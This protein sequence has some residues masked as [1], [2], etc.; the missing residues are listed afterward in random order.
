MNK[1]KEKKSKSKLSKEKNKNGDKGQYRDITEMFKQ[2]KSKSIGEPKK[3]APS[4][5]KEK[6]KKK[7]NETNLTTSKSK[8]EES[9]SE[10][11]NKKKLHKSKEKEEKKKKN[12]IIIDD[13]SSAEYNP[14]I[15]SEKSIKKDKTKKSISK[16]K[17]KSEDEMEIDEESLSIDVTPAKKRP[18]KPEASRRGTTNKKS[19]KKNENEIIGPLSNIT[20]VLTGEFPIS[21]DKFTN[22][23]KGLGARVTGSVSSKT[24]MLIH[25]DKLEDG[26]DFD[27][28]NKYKEA[29]KKKVTI[30][31]LGDFEEYMRKI[32]C[33]ENWSLSTAEIKSGD[34]NETIKIGK[35]DKKET[36]K[37]ENKAINYEGELW[38]VKY[39]PQELNDIIGNTKVISNFIE[40][41]DD[42]EDVVI[43]GNK[44]QTKGSFK[45]GRPHFENVNARACLITGDPGIGKT[46]SVR[47]I[48]KLKG[49]RTFETNASEQRNK[50]SINSKVGFLFDN[51][52]LF[53]GDIQ[54]KNLIIMDEVDGMSG[55]EDRGGIAALID[56]IKKTRVP[57]VCIANDRQNRKLKTLV[58]YCYDL[59]FNKPDKRQISNRLMQI[60]QKENIQC[61]MNAL[62]FLC[63]SVGNDIRQC[64]NFVEMWAKNHNS[65]KFNEIQQK[66]GSFNKDSVCMISNFDAS[67]KLLNSSNSKRMK[68]RELLDLYFIDYDLIPLLIYENYLSCFHYPSKT[69]ELNNLAYSSDLLSTSD[70]LE[71]RIRGRQ[72]W[73]LLPDKGVLGSVSVC[74]F[75][76]GSVGFPKFPE[77]MGKLMTLKKTKREL[78]ELKLCFP[79]CP[80]KGIKNEI[81]PLV[82]S[83]ITNHINEEQ[84]D[85]CLDIMKKHKIT[86]ELFK[87]NILDLSSE[88]NRVAF[89]HLGSTA[90][91]ALTR[92][93]NKNFKTSIIRKKGGKAKVGEEE[94]IAGGKRFDAEGNCIEE[95]GKGSKSKNEEEDDENDEESLDAS[96]VV[97]GKEKKTKA[98]TK[99]KTKGKTKK[100]EK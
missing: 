81:A 5:N 47:L 31:N 13:E 97:N 33:N 100:K 45:G 82:L 19:G 1:S 50:L 59:K 73:S 91:S 36:K 51:T 69:E 75:I 54:T 60:C 43:N 42:W 93:Y 6:L 11:V 48:A 95:D 29:V 7:V 71:K 24:S 99:G 83:L 85:S 87:E 20:I 96:L 66:Y 23:L 62:E 92:E 65:I 44:K 49:Y 15:S 34:A 17:K 39:H 21:R 9:E 3:E 14:S 84:Y 63:E 8:K 35:T 61:E 98:K 52:T 32:L 16:K 58:N 76:R 18:R 74:H 37:T 67:Q 26:R 28:G 27:Q 2:S 89:E 10:K 41:L 80:R 56:I 72:D 68:F 25:G 77:L 79:N 46:S 70:I 30:Y 40:W 90:K 57:I 64:I 22:I 88:K 78:K 94:S 86:M 12:K 38:S 53:T 4:P 55:N